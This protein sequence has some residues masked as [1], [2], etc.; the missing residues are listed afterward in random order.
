[1]S[2]VF[3][4]LQSANRNQ[5]KMITRSPLTISCLA[6]PV[7][8]VD[9]S[10]FVFQ[11]HLI[12][13]RHRIR[14]WCQ[15]AALLLVIISNET[16]ISE[17]CHDGHHSSQLVNNCT[18]DADCMIFGPSFR[19]LEVDSVQPDATGQWRCEDIDIDDDNFDWDDLNSIR[20]DLVWFCLFLVLL[21]ILLGVYHCIRH[22]WYL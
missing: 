16:A 12:I 9:R 1:M 21:A 3:D 19:C 4:K 11:P 13:T 17:T 6:A 10:F 14:M 2:R 22:N 20:S 8:C 18:T 15:L 7:F 5:L